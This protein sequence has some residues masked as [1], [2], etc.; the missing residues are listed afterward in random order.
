MK[1]LCVLFAAIGIGLASYAQAP[2]PQKTDIKNHPR[3]NQVNTRVD[4]QEKG[5]N[6][7]VKDGDLNKQQARKDKKNL[8]TINQEKKDMRKEN[9]GHLT[10][11]D[12]KLLNKQL[13]KNSKNIGK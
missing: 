10:K 9:N 3:V 11:T 5:I 1:K 2:G 6:K 13:N 12:Q 4:R 8:S 7:G